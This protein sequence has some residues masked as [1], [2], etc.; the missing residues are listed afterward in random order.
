VGCRSGGVPALAVAANLALV[1][2]L[3]QHAVEVVGLDPHVAR[4]LGD[5][6]AGLRAHE[7]DGLR[8]ARVLT[9][10]AAWTP[11]SRA[12]AVHRRGRLAARR[13]DIR[14]GDAVERGRRGLESVEL[15]D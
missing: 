11:A 13:A 5:R 14:P 12:A 3:R 9:A 2:E 10:A 7:F 4:E 1:G 6:D 8:R 15:V